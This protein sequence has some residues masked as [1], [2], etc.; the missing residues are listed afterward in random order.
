MTA[1][2]TSRDE[3]GLAVFTFDFFLLDV[4]FAEA[5]MSPNDRHMLGT[6]CSGRGLFVGVSSTPLVLLRAKAGRDRNV[7]RNTYVF[8]SGDG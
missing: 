7:R 6:S 2:A 3:N 1:Y 4:A 8:V 5:K